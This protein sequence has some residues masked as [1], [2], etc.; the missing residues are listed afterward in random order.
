MPRLKGAPATA[1]QVPNE[2]EAPGGLGEVEKPVKMTLGGVEHT[3]P[4]WHM[5]EISY[6]KRTPAEVEKLRDQF[7]RA[8]KAFMNDL[9]E[10]DTAEL[11]DAG[12][13]DEDITLMAKGQV[14]GDYEV[15]HKLPLD[16]GGTNALSN[17][18]L[19]KADPDH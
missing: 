16:D 11:R 9:A 7:E 13:S 14:P 19:I 8:R 15:H 6:T 4:D 10:N 17:L 5:E 2:V 1:A 18:M 3:M 12:M